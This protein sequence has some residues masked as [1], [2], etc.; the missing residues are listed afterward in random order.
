M[1]CKLHA[2]N[3]PSN[4]RLWSLTFSK[5]LQHTHFETLRRCTLTSSSILFLFLLLFFRI[6]QHDYDSIR[7]NPGLPPIN[8]FYFGNRTFADA[9][10]AC[11]EPHATRTLSNHDY[12]VYVVHGRL[13]AFVYGAAIGPLAPH[14]FT[15]EEFNQTENLFA[16]GTGCLC[17]NT[18]LI[19][20]ALATVPLFALLHSSIYSSCW[21]KL[22]CFGSSNLALKDVY[23]AHIETAELTSKCF[24]IR[25]MGKSHGTCLHHSP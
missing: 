9:V 5:R 22:A 6:S 3:S 24:V 1:S 23:S 20:Y 15:G 19:C 16:G 11:G 7:F 14:W 2:V 4:T 17:V 10:K 18:I 25:V 13:S 8:D 12:T 21:Y